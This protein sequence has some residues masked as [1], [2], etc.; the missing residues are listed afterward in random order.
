MTRFLLALLVLVAFPAEA[1]N[2]RIAIEDLACDGVGVMTLGAKIRYLGAKAP[3][4]SPVVRLV[5]AGGRPR[6]PR[7]L[8]WK[9]GSKTLAALLASGGVRALGAGEETGV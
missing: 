6:V 7:S 2:W 3:V 4:E 5:D 9:G 8:V 1:R